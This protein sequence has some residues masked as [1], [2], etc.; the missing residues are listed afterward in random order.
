MKKK[1]NLSHI[2]YSKWSEWK[3]DQNGQGWKIYYT[4][5]TCQIYVKF[6][7]LLPSSFYRYLIFFRRQS[8]V[9]LSTP[10][11]KIKNIHTK[12]YGIFL[13]SFL[14]IPSS[15]MFRIHPSPFLIPN[16]YHPRTHPSTHQKTN[17]L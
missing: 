11:K 15:N 2:T 6:C 7:F 14:R 10:S 3:C 5:S 9:C 13:W 1:E 12:K 8:S 4:D 16:Y 17:M